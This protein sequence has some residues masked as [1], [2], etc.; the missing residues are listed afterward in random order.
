[1]ELTKD[2]SAA[3]KKGTATT[4]SRKD[5]RK[6]MNR[7]NDLRLY[8]RNL[9]KNMFGGDGGIRPA[10]FVFGIKDD[11]A[12]EENQTETTS[13]EKER[14]R[15]LIPDA[16]S[17]STCGVKFEDLAEQRQHFKMDWHRYNLRQRLD[18]ESSISED[19]FERLIEDLE[20]N[21]SLSASS[22]NE[23]DEESIGS[24][25]VNEDKRTPVREEVEEGDKD[26]QEEEICTN[27]GESRR[28]RHPFVFFETSEKKLFSIHKCVVAE[29]KSDL[30]DSRLVSLVPKAASERLQWAVFMLGGGHFAGAVFRGAEPIL[31]KTFHCYTVRAKQGGSQGASDSTRGHA[32]SAGAS[33]RRYNEQALVQHVQDIVREWAAE[34]SACSLVFYRAASGNANVLFGGKEPPLHRRDPRLRSIPFP[35]RR[36]TF[37]EVKRVHELLA[38]IRYHGDSAEAEKQ[39]GENAVPAAPVQTSTSK[40]KKSRG[41]AQIRRSKSREERQRRLP[42]F[43][44]DLAD[45]SSSSDSDDDA[46]V[47][48]GLKFDRITSSTSVFREFDYSPM[49]NKRKKARS[50]TSA[51]QIEA[52]VENGEK[53]GDGAGGDLNELRN[54]LL[55]AC[56]TGNS[57]ALKECLQDAEDGIGNTTVELLLNQER[58]GSNRLTALHLAS[59]CGKKETIVLLL[60]NGADPTIKDKL[61]KVMFSTPKSTCLAD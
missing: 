18:G 38:T 32:K 6:P 31:H 53:D 40:K 7:D 2:G 21:L 19:A 34:I 59:D 4:K 23:S 22:D 41:G 48:D 27:S 52:V 46:K 8:D 55:T 12:V 28:D 1:M 13:M 14:H 25:Y 50:K 51:N 24:D 39:F 54:R 44:Q 56:K 9:A 33:L 58:F 11:K 20:D 10:P 45:R 49:K 57:S 37:S 16:K 42:E 47:D 17:C 61:K 30:T 29:K 5:K 26:D 35:T 15:Q 36:A 43:V 3:V 60:V